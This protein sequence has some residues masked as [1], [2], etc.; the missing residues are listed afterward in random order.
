MRGSILWGIFGKIR[1][2]FTGIRIM[3]LFSYFVIILIC[4]VSVGAI[5]FYISYRSVSERVES[6]SLQIV[7]QIEKN[8]DN[9]FQN[10]RNLLLAPYYSQEYIDG[11]N[12][13]ATMDEQAQ[14][15][16]RQKLENLFLKI[17][18]ITPIRDFIR[19]Q[20]Y[21]SNGEMLNASDNQKSWTADDVQQS[22]WFRQ[23]VVND[24]RV[25]FT[26]PTK[27]MISGSEET[28]YSSSILIRDFANPDYFIVVRAEYNAELFHPYWSER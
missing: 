5:S 26:G 22:D 17:F 6:S 2:F 8:M 28:A 12:V 27:E 10:K 9:D 18:N 25:H 20:I 21:Y 1:S 15:L 3:L 19:F 23:T 24:G 16:F 4:I 7:R 11:I 13:Y 14:F